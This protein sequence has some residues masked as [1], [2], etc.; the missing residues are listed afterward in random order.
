MSINGNVTQVIIAPLNAVSS[1]SGALGH[2]V[3]VYAITETGGLW[4]KRLAS[5]PTIRGADTIETTQ[6]WEK[7]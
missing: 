3:V 1:S 7:Q 5:D 2:S 4:E 6:D